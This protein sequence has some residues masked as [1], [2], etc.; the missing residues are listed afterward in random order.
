M[1]GD[2]VNE[3]A[4][5]FLSQGIVGV[6]LLVALFAILY[7]HKNH[8]EERD[9]W[10]AR[11]DR[12]RSAAEARHKEEMKT[13]AEHSDKQLEMFMKHQEGQARD[14]KAAFDKIADRLAHGGGR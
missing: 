7:L 5:G 3:V 12:E 11:Q 4:Q 2:I 6:M 8:G 13:V 1:D 9:E 10:Y 14:L